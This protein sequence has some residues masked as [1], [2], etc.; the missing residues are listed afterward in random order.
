MNVSATRLDGVHIIEPD[1]IKDKRG[2]FY[3]SFNYNKFDDYFGHF[4]IIQINQSKS[5]SGVLRG[6]HFQKPPITQA[7]VVEVL[8]GVILDVV[9]DIRTDSPT[10]G[11]YQS[12]V[13]DDRYK[14]QL[15]ISRGFAHGFV[16]LSETATFQYL[17]DNHYS[18]AHDCGIRF[19][20]KDLNIDWETENPIVSDKDIGL[21]QF[22]KQEYYKKHEYF[23]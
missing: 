7:K 3:E 14:E 17:V 16:V 10:F 20:D 19:N 12:F 15:F 22:K 2:H 8:E 23:Q 6:L 13:L 4:K 11:Q 21:K 18:P 9:V 5:K 1:I